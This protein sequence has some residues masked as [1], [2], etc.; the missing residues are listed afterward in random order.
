[1]QFGERVRNARKNARI[2][3]Q[4]LADLVG[5]SKMTIRRIEAGQTVKMDIANR[6]AAILS[7]P[8]SE[9]EELEQKTRFEN[10]VTAEL[11]EHHY[12]IPERITKALYKLNKV[13]KEEAV[14][15]VEELTE[16]SRFTEGE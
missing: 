13:G 11:L 6:I 14:V 5:V 9:V 7:I 4:E 8:I 15:R 10:E 1:M 16:I 3:Q 2:T 12:D